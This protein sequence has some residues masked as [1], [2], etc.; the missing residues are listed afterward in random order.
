[1]RKNKKR[2]K[3]YGH[4]FM[5]DIYGCCPD[6]LEDIKRCYSYLDKIPGLIGAKKI[7]PPFVIYTDGEKYPDKAGLSGWIPIIDPNS[8]K[9]SGVS[10]HTLA[11]TKFISIDIYSCKKINRK[12]IIEFTQKVFKP[13]KIEEQYYIRGLDYCIG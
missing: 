12:K 10:I 4:Y 7:S 2:K 3:N 9:Y 11:P 6:S 1:M 8:K 13:K 5:I